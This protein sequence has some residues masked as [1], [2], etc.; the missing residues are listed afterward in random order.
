MAAVLPVP[1]VPGTVVVPAVAVG[2]TVVAGTT[3][4]AAIPAAVAATAEAHTIVFGAAPGSPEPPEKI[5]R[6]LKKGLAFSEN[7]WYHSKVVS[8]SDT[9]RGSSSVG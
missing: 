4:V 2:T 3:A 1:S 6:N 5:F 8:E 7:M 9:T